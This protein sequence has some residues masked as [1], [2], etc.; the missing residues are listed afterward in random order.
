MTLDGVTRQRERGAGKA[1]ERHLVSQF[2]TQ[3]LN[4]VLHVAG[5]G[6][7]I[8][9]TELLNIGDSTHGVVDD[10]AS[11]ALE[12]EIEAHARKTDEDV[13][14]HDGCV[15]TDE[16][17]RLHRDLDRQLGR[18]AHLKE[19]VLL[20]DGAVFGHVA[21]CL[22]HHPD[23]RA[24]GLLATGGTEK[25]VVVRHVGRSFHVGTQRPCSRRRFYHA[26]ARDCPS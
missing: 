3:Y 16:V 19:A 9:D 12:L 15:D 24:L 11:P 4:D 20:A 21:P 6:D 1:D 13:G 17:D 25:E 10:R 22:S 8:G 14:E 18:P 7:G 5:V 2:S 26:D 23:G